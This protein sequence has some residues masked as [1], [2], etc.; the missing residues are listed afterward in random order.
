[1]NEPRTIESML[2]AQDCDTIRVPAVS[3]AAAS[4]AAAI[5]AEEVALR[6]VRGQAPLTAHDCRVAREEY[7]AAVEGDEGPVYGVEFVREWEAQS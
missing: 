1:M 5:H 4:E 6:A 3:L 2:A 7:A